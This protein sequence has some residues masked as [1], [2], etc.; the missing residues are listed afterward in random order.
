MSAAVATHRPSKD[1]TP[2]KA[3]KCALVRSRFWL[4]TSCRLRFRSP[5]DKPPSVRLRSFS[6]P[7][8]PSEIVDI[9]GIEDVDPVCRV[10]RKRK[11]AARMAA[12]QASDQVEKS[13]K[14]GA[15]KEKGFEAM[16]E[17]VKPTSLRSGGVYMPPA[18]LRALQAA[19]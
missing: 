1:V 4:L 11:L 13:E 12:D 2:D 9:S 8:P 17:I 15:A 14:K 5:D 3:K 19:Q 10:E 6:P 7:P 18:R 16:A